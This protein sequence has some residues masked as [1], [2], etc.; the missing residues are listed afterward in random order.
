MPA[1]TMLDWERFQVGIVLATY[2]CNLNHFR[3]QVDSLRN[4]DFGRWLCLVTDD[5]STEDCRQ[6]IQQAI[7]ADER[8][9][10]HVQTRNLGSYHNFEYGLNYFYKHTQVTHI[11]FSDQDDVWHSH[12]LATLLREIEA[13]NALLA[14]SDLELIDG[15][16]KLL[17]P[18]V[19][20]YEGRKPEKLDT[21]LLL[22]RNTVTGCTL[23]IRRALI[24][25]ILPFPQQQQVGCW[26]HDHW[27]ALAAAC[28]GTIVHVRQPLVRYRQHGSNTVG[29]EQHAGTIRKELELWVAKGG[30]LTLQSYP[31]HRDLSRAFYGRFHP[32]FERDLFSEGRIDFGFSIL[33]LGLRSVLAGYGARGIVLRLWANKFILD[34]LKIKNSFSQVFS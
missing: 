3:K 32:G 8:F 20:Q 5:G 13:N 30:R 29:A 26:Y 1:P 6:Q 31:V 15:E 9:I 27:I 4:Q 25:H 34:I 12:K 7:G 33:K 11:A 22:L 28:L 10:Y 2:N 17:S 18:S 14:H 21:E 24:P 23:M 16:D 19:W